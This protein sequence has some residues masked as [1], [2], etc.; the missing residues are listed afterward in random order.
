[1]RASLPFA[2]LGVAL[3]AGAVSAAGDMPAFKVERWVNSAPLT[4]FGP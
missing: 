4:A 1:M 3:G 2:F